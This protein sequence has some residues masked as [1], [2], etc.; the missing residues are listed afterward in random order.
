MNTKKCCDGDV[1][2][3]VLKRSVP[4]TLL[5][6]CQ[7]HQHAEGVRAGVVYAL[8]NLVHECDIIVRL[9]PVVEE[10]EEE[11]EGLHYR[12]RARFTVREKPSHKEKGEWINLSET[13]YEQ[14]IPIKTT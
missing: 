11:E 1:E 7:D 2:V 6:R 12:V 3:S 5:V 9:M 8:Q 10:E 13:Y 4:S 14:E